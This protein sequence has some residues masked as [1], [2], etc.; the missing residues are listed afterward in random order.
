MNKIDNLDKWTKLAKM[1][2]EK[3]LDKIAKKIGRN[4]RN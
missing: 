3:K 1:E 2:N 4:R